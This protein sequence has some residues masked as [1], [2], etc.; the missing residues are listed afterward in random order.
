ML[1][2]HYLVD[3]TEYATQYSIENFKAVLE[4]VADSG[5]RVLPLTD[6]WDHC[7]PA[8][9]SAAREGACRF[10]QQVAAPDSR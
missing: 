3:K 10:P 4:Q 7:A 5:I 9:H 8:Q 2:F 6:V 1:M